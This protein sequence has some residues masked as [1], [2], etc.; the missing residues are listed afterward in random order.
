M[1]RDSPSAVWR[2]AY[3]RRERTGESRQGWFLSC[4]AN[5]ARDLVRARGRKVAASEIACWIAR[6]F[7]QNPP[8]I[9]ALRRAI[10]YG[11]SP[12][13]TSGSEKEEIPMTDPT[14]FQE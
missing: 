8:D 11:R 12:R 5:A 13:S 1:G 6:E 3:C 7:G 14:F 2:I 9:R 4:Y 10:S